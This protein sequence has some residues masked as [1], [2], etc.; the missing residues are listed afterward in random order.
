VLTDTS[1]LFEHDVT[2]SSGRD[3]IYALMSRKDGRL[4]DNYKTIAFADLPSIGEL[5]QANFG[6][7]ASDYSG[8]ADPSLRLNHYQFS[9]N[10]TSIVRRRGHVILGTKTGI[11]TRDSEQANYQVVQVPIAA[12][13]VKALSSALNVLVANSE[14]LHGDFLFESNDFGQTWNKL[15]LIADT[16]DSVTVVPRGTQMIAEATHYDGPYD[17]NTRLFSSNDGK[18]W[19][20]L[21]LNDFSP[22]SICVSG[23]RLYALSEGQLYM[24][25]FQGSSFQ[26]WGVKAPAS[27]LIPGDVWACGEHS[28]IL[29]AEM[30]SDRVTEGG[31]SWATIP[32]IDR[33]T[34]K[35]L[36][37]FGD[38]VYGID[39]ANTLY[40]LDDIDAGG[41]RKLPAIGIPV[42]DGPIG[43]N[44]ATVIDGIWVDASN[45][46]VIMLA[47]S[48]GVLWSND[49]GANFLVSDV[50]E[51]AHSITSAGGHLWIATDHG[52]SYLQD[53]VP[54]P[55]AWDEI[56]QFLIKGKDK[57]A[58][59]L[60]VL[61][62]F[63]FCSTRLIL[64]LLQWNAPIIKDA[65]S[66]FYLTRYGRWRLF[67][68][69]R[70][71]LLKDRDI[72]AAIKDFVELP[73]LWKSIPP[74]DVHK[75]LL[76]QLQARGEKAN[77]TLIAQGG[78]GKSTI[79]RR[80]VGLS[81][82]GKLAIG[83]EKREPVIIEGFSFR[84]DLVESIVNALKRNRAYV[85]TPIVE[86][87]LELG[88]LMVIFDGYSEIP[89]AVLSGVGNGNLI[90]V[91]SKYPD[92]LFIFTSRS[93]L[94]AEMSASFKLEYP[95]EILA[96]DAETEKAFF[97][98]YLGDE[99]SAQ[100]LVKDIIEVFPDLPRIP[101]ILR[102][103]AHF[104][105][106]N[107]RIPG[108]KASLFSDYTRDL[109]LPEK[110]GVK[111]AAGV[112]YAIEHIVRWSHIETDG[113]R[114]FLL[115]DAILLLLQIAD[116]LEK[117]YGISMAAI[118]LLTILRRA[119]LFKSNGA[120]WRFLHDSFESYYAGRVFEK[121]F[122]RR[123]YAL[124]ARAKLSPKLTDALEFFYQLL[125][126]AETSVADAAT[127]KE[128][129]LAPIPADC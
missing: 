49:G 34:F 31:S 10:L 118:D 106:Q 13:K 68:P 24:S 124:I 48:L 62:I 123:N 46:Q 119:G 32:N 12:V 35:S 98:S 15:N 126:E 83:G 120:Y 38:H 50:K 30:H 2:S 75:P 55:I 3:E 47:T 61:C 105:K 64:L 17:P 66:A 4:V 103:I 109:L 69:Y 108:D 90:S 70:S 37:A 67:R 26:K 113:D 74:G 125:D 53:N 25:A 85:N 63:A 21:H 87:Q 127:L 102:L 73:Y 99:Q 59:A 23:Q 43:Q 41:W 94:P 5:Q 33:S 122:R 82:L 80:I 52:V 27:E 18:V 19:S 88:R 71:S 56:Q 121:E 91:V 20:P 129:N 28:V 104:Y 16:R 101:L 96:L 116:H 7:S 39:S 97:T 45:A 76:D 60:V 84:G 115:D 78:A 14:E 11:L 128:Q 92:T 57:A 8:V 9:D 65:A 54:R 22:S 6:Y 40:V 111:E 86:S 117:G 77:L 93:P 95:I 100:R 72:A 44:G 29:A 36:R 107:G 81:V 110:I 51:P 42:G 58:V 79:C 114:G 1:L 89:S 112:H